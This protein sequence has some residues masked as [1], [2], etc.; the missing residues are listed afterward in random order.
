MCL[1]F[2]CYLLHCKKCLQ[3]LIKLNEGSVNDDIL[4]FLLKMVAQIFASSLSM[5]INSCFSF[6]IFQNELK[7]AKVM[8]VIKK[9][10]SNQ[11]CGCGSF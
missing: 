5:L 8:T 7:L 11:G 9:R 2:I 3:Q 1:P 10:P 4:P 6:G